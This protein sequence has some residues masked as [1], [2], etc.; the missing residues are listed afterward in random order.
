MPFCCLVLDLMC[1]E[2]SCGHGAITI[3]QF[4]LSIE[5]CPLSFG[6]LRR[7]RCTRWAAV[8]SSVTQRLQ[9]LGAQFGTTKSLGQ[10]REFVW[11]VLAHLQFQRLWND[12]AGKLVQ[13]VIEEVP[14]C[15]MRC[16]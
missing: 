4:L 6:I 16:R 11:T 15:S 2:W 7:S 8:L 14:A 12:Q 3:A 13:W 9:Q 10:Q 5:V 1:A